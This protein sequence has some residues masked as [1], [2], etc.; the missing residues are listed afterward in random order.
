MR[1]YEGGGERR[2]RRR[3]RSD[4]ERRGFGGSR[5]LLEAH[6]E[7][8]TAMHE[9]QKGGKNARKPSG[10]GRGGGREG[11]ERENRSYVGPRGL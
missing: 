2:S 4:E 9:E 8:A 1:D 10:R 11:E 3:A 5:F 7:K 6:L